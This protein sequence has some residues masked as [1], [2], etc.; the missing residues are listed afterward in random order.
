M[1]AVINETTRQR[2]FGGQPALGKSIEV[3]GQ[4]FSVVGVVPDVPILRLVPFARHLGAAHH[5]QVR[6][7]HAKTWSAIS[8][9]CCC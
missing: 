7:L 2:F 5:G 9:A 6:Q 8:W 3:D 1:V 4:R